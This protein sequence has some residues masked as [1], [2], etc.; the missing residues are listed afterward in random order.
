MTDTETSTPR[1]APLSKERVLDAAVAFADEHGIE[2]LS[3]RR[4]AK[5]LGV[6]AMSLY[7]HVA[8][9]DDLLAGIIDLVTAEIELP[10]VDGDWKAAMRA[11]AISAKDTFLR[12]KWLSALMHS[13]QSGGPATL[14]RGEWMLATLRD[15]GFS[16]DLTYHAFHIINAYLL[17]VTNQHLSVPPAGEDLATLARGFL[18]ELPQDKYPYTVEHIEQHI[19]P[20]HQHPG[21]FELG[22]EF[23]LDGLER[24]RDAP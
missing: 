10:E 24:L 15:A 12:H 11:G 14:R 20:D 6:E 19:D 22:L 5:E 8:N 16:A 9:K 18:A 23:I 1:R 2:A 21:G 3:M 13:K 7:N 4:L 17:G